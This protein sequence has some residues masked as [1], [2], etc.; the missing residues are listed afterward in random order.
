[1]PFSPFYGKRK[2]YMV[3]KPPLLELAH[4]NVK[5]WQSQSDQDNLL[6][7]ARVPILLMTGVDADDKK[8]FEVVV[9]ASN[10]VK[11]PKDCDMKYVE[12]TGASIE[13]GKVSLDDLQE[14]M[15]QAGASMLVLQPGE[16]TATQ[17]EHEADPARCALE[18]MVLLFEDTLNLAME[19][20]AK[21]VG[22]PK[23]GTLKLFKDFG[24]ATL[25]EASA[26]LLLQSKNV[27]VI[28]AETYFNE[29]KRRGIVAPDVDWDEEQ[30]RVLAEGPPPGQEDDDA[31]PGKKPPGNKTP[32]KKE[33]PKKE[34]PTGDE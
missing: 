16:I 12:H 9:G 3:G 26:S 27:G 21:W 4:L 11:L 34:P 31:P 2:G 24:A 15:R 18:R 10:A 32:T 19:Y 14:E 25:A 7:V 28:S 33:P 17:V 22:Q 1:V 6:H 30:E 29:L 5:H 8:K 23:G 13:A 20:T